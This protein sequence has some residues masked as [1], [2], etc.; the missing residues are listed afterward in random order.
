MNASLCLE[1]QV[2]HCARQSLSAITKT[3]ENSD[4]PF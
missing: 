4:F 1:P 3:K 2:P